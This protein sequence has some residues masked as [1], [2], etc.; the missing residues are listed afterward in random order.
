MP[1]LRSSTLVSGGRR[2][3]Q[4]YMVSIILQ[5]STKQTPSRMTLIPA[6]L[7]VFSGSLHHTAVVEPASTNQQSPGFFIGCHFV[8]RQILT[9]VVPYRIAT[10]QLLT[11]N[12]PITMNPCLPIPHPQSIIILYP[13]I[14]LHSVSLLFGTNILRL[15]KR[16]T[17]L[18][19]LQPIKIGATRRLPSRLHTSSPWLEQILR[20]FRLIICPA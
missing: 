5:S 8:F 16:S 13:H 4:K 17:A 10:C 9:C 7:V 20:F 1:S 2:A 3:S 14:Y 19:H 15:R 11:A 6:L 18:Q 12:T